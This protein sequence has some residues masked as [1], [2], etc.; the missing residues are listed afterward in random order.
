[1]VAVVAVHVIQAQVV[2]VQTADLVV[3]LAEC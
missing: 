2:V 3:A 1:V